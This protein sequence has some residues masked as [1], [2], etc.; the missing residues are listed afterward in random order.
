MGTRSF[1]LHGLLA[2]GLW[3]VLSTPCLADGLH[4][5]P[6][7]VTLNNPEATQQILVRSSSPVR[8]VTHAAIYESLDPRIAVVDKMGRVQPISEGRTAIVVR[9]GAEQARVPVDI[10]GLQKPA[11]VAFD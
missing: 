9:H 2:L 6:T 5:S 10:S 3:L 11:P 7:T 8:D 4:V 1:R